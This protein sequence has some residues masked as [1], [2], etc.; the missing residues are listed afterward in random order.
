MEQTPLVA[1][2]TDWKESD[3]RLGLV[4]LPFQMER[5]HNTGS[6]M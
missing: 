6:E 1:P 3:L 5:K 4:L 2:V